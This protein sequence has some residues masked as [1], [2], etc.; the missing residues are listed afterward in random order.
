MFRLKNASRIQ[1]VLICT[2]LVHTL[3]GTFIPQQ[4]AAQTEA[5]AV[6]SANSARWQ[7]N[8]PSGML[9]VTGSFPCL[10]WPSNSTP[11]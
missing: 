10:N 5:S 7:R 6:V 2:L 11:P 9:M 8:S 3:L 4:V 1:V